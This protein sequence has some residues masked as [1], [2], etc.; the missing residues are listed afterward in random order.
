MRC[1][2]PEYIRKNDFAIIY[3]NLAKYRSENNFVKP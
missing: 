3:K 1:K 2:V